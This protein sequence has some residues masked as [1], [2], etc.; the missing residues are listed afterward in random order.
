MGGGRHGR[1]CR[2]RR[3]LDARPK[4]TYA[5]RGQ[6]RR[7]PTGRREALGRTGRVAVGYLLLIA[8]VVVLVG[9]LTSYTSGSTVLALPGLLGHLSFAIAG[10]LGLAG[11]LTVI[12]R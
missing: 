1:R 3:A 8:A 11:F 10:F 5:R 4:R 7:R 9:H 12:W 6:P 2:R